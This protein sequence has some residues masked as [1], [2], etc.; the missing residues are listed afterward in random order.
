[1]KL[2]Y[3]NT[4][5]EAYSC[6]VKTILKAAEKNIPKT[7]LETKRRLTVVWWNEECEREER[8]VRAEYKNTGETKQTELIK[9]IPT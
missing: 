1:M 2:Q 3:Q 4:I 6:L 9:N 8:M 5:K 7:F